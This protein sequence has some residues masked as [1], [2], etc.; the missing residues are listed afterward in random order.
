MTT[1]LPFRLS[2]TPAEPAAPTTQADLCQVLDFGDSRPT[3]GSFQ[4]DQ[5]SGDYELSWESLAEF[6]TWRQE[7]QQIDSID[8]LLANTELSTHYFSWRRIYQCSRQ[9]SGGIKP[10]E[11]KFPDWI[12]NFGPKWIGCPC[13]VDL[14][15][16]P[17]THIILGQYIRTHDHPIG[18]ENLIYT[19]L[20]KKAKGQVRGF[21][22]QQVERRAIVCNHRLH[23][24][25]S[26]NAL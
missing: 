18:M 10:Y 15:G 5:E 1:L 17:G 22:E 25:G 9:G 24:L 7:Q 21:L 26:A 16:Y 2:I 11:K 14:K 8:L 23:L 6:D 12:Q 20:S 3:R 19:Q 4:H 13:K